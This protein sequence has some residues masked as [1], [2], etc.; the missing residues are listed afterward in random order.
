MKPIRKLGL[1]G[2]VFVVL[3]AALNFAAMQ[4]WNVPL[5]GV[6]QANAGTL[7][8]IQMTCCDTGSW[9]NPCVTECRWVNGASYYTIGCF[10]CPNTGC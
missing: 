9:I 4:N 10:S 7:G 6:P 1:L 5:L 3:F 8:C 2:V